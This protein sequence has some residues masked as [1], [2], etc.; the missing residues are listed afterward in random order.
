[1]VGT[2]DREASGAAEF[3]AIDVETAN[4]DL[5]SICQIGIVKFKNKEIV[6]E[7]SSLINPED[8][9]SGFNIGI[10]G[11]S[12]N[13]VKG[14]PKFPEIAGEIKNM[15]TG[16][17][18]VSHTHFD[19]VSVGRALEKHGIDQIATK[20]LDSAKV[21]RR[22][23]DVCAWRGYGLRSIC[24]ILGYEF[25][26]HDALED[27]RA[28]GHVMIAACEKS[29]FGVDE[30]LLRAD[31][32]ISSPRPDRPAISAKQSPNRQAKTPSKKRESRANPQGIFFG[33]V[34]VFTGSLSIV[35]REAAALAEDAGCH[36]GDGVTWDTTLLVV[37]DQDI[38]RLHGK[39]KTSKHIK[40]EK[41]IQQGR[42][43]RILT[44]SDFKAMLDE[45][46]F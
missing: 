43:L 33:E 26:H 3:V 41:M 17:V 9:F 18:T 37:G 39:E 20:W 8:D 38:R 46:P 40:A 11:I 42:P 45:V 19:R 12:E 44:E 16:M 7:W 29:G 32:P 4:P 15:L 13:D 34:I 30:W 1:M 5:A 31:L 6:V 22:V 23:W 10:H 25:R 24:D 28:C 35:R 14:A 36:V 21:A 2:E 27:A